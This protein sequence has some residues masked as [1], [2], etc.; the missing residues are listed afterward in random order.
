MR[1]PPN[2]KIPPPT[3]ATPLKRKV[4]HYHKPQTT[5]RKKPVAALEWSKEDV[6]EWLKDNDLAELCG[7]FKKMNGNHLHGLY[8][9]Y[10]NSKEKVYE[11]VKSDYELKCADCTVFFKAL[12]DAFTE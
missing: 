10:C 8:S 4:P 6:Q 11:E 2:Q 12:K 1:T 3:A 9:R 5:K 7:Q